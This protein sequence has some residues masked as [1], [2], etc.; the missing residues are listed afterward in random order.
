MKRVNRL[1]FTALPTAVVLGLLAVLSTFPVFGEAANESESRLLKD[2]KYLASDELEGRG[3]GTNGLNKAADFVRNAFREAGLDVTTVEGEAFQPFTMT[4]GSKLGKTNTLAF[5]GPDGKSIDLKING[6]FQTCSFGA[7]GK[8]DGGIVFGGYAIDAKDEKYQ[9]FAEVDLKDKIVII[10][11]RNPQQGNPHGKFGGGGPVS[12]HAS[13]RTKVS[14]AFGKGAA[15]ILFV[16][17]PYS[18]R[19]NAKNDNSLVEKETGRLVAAAEALVKTD[20]KD[21]EK[22]AA[23]R[24]KLAESVKRLNAAKVAADKTDDDDPL[25]RFGYGGNASGKSIPILHVTVKAVD[26]LLQASLKKSLADLEAEIDKDVKPQTTA[27]K[28]WKATGETSLEVTKVEVKNVI[29]VLEGE[30]PL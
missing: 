13:L 29:G 28:G 17:D 27:L 18:I 6:D 30:G 3:V 8:F 16:N 11:R 24:K 2:I 23:A 15:A 25:M 7:A 19:K 5:T 21:A 14:N 9:D 12:V 10:M 22:T 1:G 4:T 26:Q 20:A